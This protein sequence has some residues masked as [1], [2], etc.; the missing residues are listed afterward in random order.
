MCCLRCVLFA[1]VD[2]NWTTPTEGELQAVKEEKNAILERQ[3]REEAEAIMQ[4]RGYNHAYGG[5][6]G[7]TCICIH[8][9]CLL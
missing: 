9:A 1:R 7:V 5:M 8:I 2:R 3:M 4:G 6:G